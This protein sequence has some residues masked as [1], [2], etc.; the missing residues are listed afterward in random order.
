MEMTKEEV[1]ERDERQAKRAAAKSKLNDLLCWIAIKQQDY[2]SLIHIKIYDDGS[3]GLIHQ[4][5]GEEE[6]IE[7]WADLEGLLKLMAPA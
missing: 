7:E 3:G 5:H 2:K 4:P 6:Y 1:K